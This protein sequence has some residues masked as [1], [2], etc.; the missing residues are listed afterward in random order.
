MRIM[1]KLTTAV[2]PGDY[3]YLQV[4]NIIIRKCF[5][6]LQLNLVGRDFF[7]PEA[8]I[9]IPEYNLQIWPGYK[10]TINQYEDKILM[11]TELTHKVM[12]MDTVIQMLRE[13]TK[14][15]GNNFKNDFVTDIT[16]QIVLTDYNK[17]TYRID[18]VDWKNT[19]LSTFKTKDGDISYVDYYY[20]KYNI[21]INDVRQPMLVSRSKLRQVRA[22][23]SELV[24]LVPE[25]CRM[26]GLSDAMRANFQLMKSIAAHTKIGPDV[27]I[28]KLLEFNKRFIQNKEVVTAQ[29]LNQKVDKSID[30]G[31]LE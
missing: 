17:R 30:N 20:K 22:G 15:K 16:G 31:C 24:Y 14:T 7:N 8:K 26:T 12:R 5:H 25:L 6:L 21:R 11:V 28:R 23:M 3:H 4:F 2:S 1:I 19:P 13:Y 29:S 10:T 9:D 27:R 18:D